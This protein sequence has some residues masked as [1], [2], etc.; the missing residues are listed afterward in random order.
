MLEIFIKF[1]SPYFAFL[2]GAAYN[3]QQTVEGAGLSSSNFLVRN[4]SGQIIDS[5]WSPAEAAY[6]PLG[7]ILLYSL[8]LL[9][10]FCVAGYALW[11]RKGI[12]IALVVSGTPGVLSLIGCWPQVNFMPEVYHIGRVG[13]LGS[14]YGMAALA[15][16]ALLS[17]WI[18]VV[19]LTDILSLQDRFRHAYDHLW[20]SM[21]ILAGL[22][23]VADAGN[24][25]EVRD[26]QDTTKN[27]QQASSYL[28]GQIRGYVKYCES[29]SIEQK[30]SCIWANDIQQTLTDYTVYDER[31]YWQLGPKSQGDLYSPI[32][33]DKEVESEIRSELR[34]FNQIQCPVSTNRHS[35]PSNTCQRP[36]SIFCTGTE[37]ANY[38]MWT[39]AV[40]N[41]CVIPTLVQLRSKMEKQVAH[42]E[43]AARTSH[44]RWV[45]YLFI[46]FL[47]GGKVANA[48]AKFT[49]AQSGATGLGDECNVR[50]L[51]STGWKSGLFVG[52]I[53]GTVL[54]YGLWLAKCTISWI[55]RIPQL[56]SQR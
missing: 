48:T 45:F 11:R 17:G 52:K 47:A 49:K 50:R 15:I 13:A 18:A 42:V 9:L 22:F 40:S 34:K 35:P 51:L 56:F 25:H 14:P 55:W 3:I 33:G 30:A 7:V 24:S 6:L 16:I 29:A 26:L 37:N 32:R 10:G 2:M 41:E 20:Y 12:A 23:F 44:A 31:L 4:T 27:V 5:Y 54:R 19:I 53:L 28:L 39:I 43:S 8:L 36:P 38:M 1:T 46:A 21:A